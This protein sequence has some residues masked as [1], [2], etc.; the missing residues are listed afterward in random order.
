MSGHAESGERPLDHQRRVLSEVIAGR[1]FIVAMETLVGAAGLAKVLRDHG[2]GDVL[3]V[4]AH[5]GTGELPAAVE[6]DAINLEVDGRGVMG[7]IRAF[8]AALEQPSRQLVEAVERFDPVAEAVVA[9]AVYFWGERLLGRQVFGARP[10]A[11]A[12]VEDKTVIDLLWD[13]A[14][15]PRARSRI[16]PVD[17]RALWRAHQDLDAGQGTVWVADNR[18]GW[19]GGGHGLRWVSTPAEAELAVEDLASMADQVR[20]M[21][22]LDGRPCSIH[23]WV[24]GD[25]LA[26]FRPCETVTLRETASSRLRY[27]GTA[28]SW[29][30]PANDQGMMRAL[31]LR[32]GAHLRDAYGFRGVFTID[33]VLTADGFRPTELNPRFGADWRPWAAVRTSRCTRCTARRWSSRISTGDQSNSSPRCSWPVRRDRMRV[34]VSSCLTAA[35]PGVPSTWNGRASGSK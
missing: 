35:W 8:V 32:V 31:A 18:S 25:A 24:I 12:E 10:R 5:R 23:G 17:R 28:T 1:R 14:G 34:V 29:M 20:V 2:A 11:W 27:A 19:H 30:P 7:G 21:P 26:T 33:G 3:I 15:V 4:G 22:F 6:P 16:E 9:T 13:D